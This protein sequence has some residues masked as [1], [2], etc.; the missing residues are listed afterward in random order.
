MQAQRVA[1]FAALRNLPTSRRIVHK[2]VDLA[3][4]QGPNNVSFWRNGSKT[5]TLTNPGITRSF[6]S[7]FLGNNTRSA[8]FT[9]QLKGQ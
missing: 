9:Q 8:S 2:E 1:I 6:M 3:I 4:A 5:C 7:I